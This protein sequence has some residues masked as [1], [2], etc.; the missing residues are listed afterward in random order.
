MRLLTRFAVLLHILTSNAAID[1]PQTEWKQ[2]PLPIRDVYQWPFL[3]WLQDIAIGTNGDIYMTTVSPDGSI[4]LANGANTDSPTISHVHKFDSMNAITGIIETKAGIYTFLGGNQTMVGFGVR[5][6]FR[7]W[8]LDTRHGGA[9][10]I[11]ERAYIPGAGLLAAVI[12]VP[13]DSNA[14]LV[15]DST[16]GRVYRVDLATGEYETILA[17]A[18]MDPPGWAPIPFGIGCLQYHKGYLYYVNTFRALLHRIKMTDNG[19]L[20]PGAK[21]ELVLELQSIYLDTF[22][23]GSDDTIWMATDADNRLLAAT[24]DGSIT[25][26]AGAPDQLTVAGVVTGAFGTLSGDESTFYIVTNGGMTVPINGTTIEGGKLA[27]VNT[28][29]F[30][31]KTPLSSAQVQIWGENTERLSNGGLLKLVVQPARYIIRC[32]LGIVAY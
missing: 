28:S 9:P 2:H 32:F 16:L 4:W 15:S 26:V 6:T 27:A 25:V 30:G 14:V 13:N 19:Y 31:Q 20:V 8:E 29:Q 18:T 7:V 17:D 11:T 23:I 12:P 1:A 5:D 3:T 24:P 21:I 10:I 22:F